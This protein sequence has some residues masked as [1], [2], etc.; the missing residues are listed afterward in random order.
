MD[1][2]HWMEGKSEFLRSRPGRRV[3]EG[4]AT[5]ITDPARRALVEFLRSRPGRRVLEGPATGITDPA[6]RA[7]VEFLRRR[8]SRREVGGAGG[9]GGSGPNTS[10][11]GNGGQGGQGGKSAVRAAPAAA[12]PTPVPAA[13][14]GKEV[15]A[16]GA[17]QPRLYGPGR[18]W[19]NTDLRASAE[20]ITLA[21][22]NPDCTAQDVPGQ[23]PTC[24]HPLNRSLW[25]CSTRSN[26]GQSRLH[27]VHLLDR[28]VGQEGG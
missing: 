19:T 7:L 13:T 2:V 4:P 16:A 28:D 22:L 8:R 24:A 27:R 21:L 3:L 1:I 20:P 9:A 14:A 25:R 6:R 15:K 5:G 26:V 17:A 10:P 18:S 11:G 23:I 12:G